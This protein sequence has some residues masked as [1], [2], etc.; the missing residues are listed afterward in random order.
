MKN[1]YNTMQ[2]CI[3]YRQVNKVTVIDHYPMP[4]IDDLFLLGLGFHI[5]FKDWF[6]I[7]LPSYKNSDN[8]YA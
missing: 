7:F 1:T 3:V 5:S 6:K 2:I 8:N 4:N